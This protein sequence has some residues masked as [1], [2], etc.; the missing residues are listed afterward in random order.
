[1]IRFSL[2][3]GQGHEFEGWFKNG[4]SFD[5]QAEGGA[6][7]CPVCADRDIRKAIMAPAVSRAT[8]PPAKT[9]QQQREVV[10]KVL[11]MMRAVQRHVEENFEHVGAQF[12][13]E[14][15]K[16]HY[17]EAELRDIYGEASRDDVADLLEEGIQIHPLPMLPKLDG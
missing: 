4:A 3:C 15:R 12:P 14:A 10:A 7:S 1:V 5:E 8:E 13:E 17:G 6:L 9:S 16:I 11:Q 2:T